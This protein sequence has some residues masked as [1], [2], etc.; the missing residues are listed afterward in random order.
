MTGMAVDSTSTIMS[1]GSTNPC[2]HRRRAWN[3]LLDRRPAHPVHAARVPAGAAC[4]GQPRCR[5]PAGR[6]AWLTLHA[7]RS[8]RPPAPLYLKSALLWRVRVRLGLGRRLPA[9]RP[10][11]LPQAAGR[12]ALH[13]GAGHAPAGRDDAWRDRLVA[14]WR[15]HWPTGAV[16]GPRAVRRRDRPRPSSAPA[17]CCAKACSSTGPRT[18]H[19]HADFADLLA[20]LQRDKRKK[21]QQERRRVADAGVTFTVHE[22]ARSTPDAVGLLPPLLHAHLPGPPQHALPDARLLRPHGATLPQRTG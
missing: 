11:L 22:G 7:G 2:R 5:A 12:R 3:E 10:A 8:C 17:G 21:I 6:R 18:A 19:P 14:A 15:E 1:S 4:L 20:R 16:V 13:A 9:P